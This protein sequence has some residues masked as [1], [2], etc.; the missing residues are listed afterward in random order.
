MLMNFLQ[1]ALA[2]YATVPAR[3]LR[4]LKKPLSGAGSAQSAPM[5]TK[6]DARL[7]A[8]WF[9]ALVDSNRDKAMSRQE[10]ETFLAAPSHDSFSF[11][12]TEFDYYD[13]D[14]SDSLSLTEL[15][16]LVLFQSNKPVLDE[17][18]QLTTQAAPVYTPEPSKNAVQAQTAMQARASQEQARPVAAPQPVA[19]VQPLAAQ[20]LA[21]VQPLA[22]QPLA[23]VQ[24]LAA[25]PVTPAQPL[26]QVQPLAEKPLAQVQ[27]LA[28]Q[29]VAPAQPLAQVQPLAAQPLAPAH[30]QT[31]TQE[32]PQA[33]AQVDMTQHSKPP[34]H[35]PAAWV[36]SPAVGSPDP[37]LVQAAGTLLQQGDTDM[38]GLLSME[39]ANALLTTPGHYFLAPVFAQFEDFDLDLNHGLDVN[40][41][42]NVLSSLVKAQGQ[43]VMGTQTLAA[44]QPV[45][46]QQ[47]TV[48][49]QP[50]VAAQT[51]ETSQQPTVPAQPGLAAQ[52]LETSQQPT[53]P[54]QP[55]LAAQTLETS[56]QPTVPA[57]PGLAAQTLETS[58]Q[59]TVPAQPGV[60]AQPLGTSQQPTVP[61]QPGLAAQPVVAVQPVSG[62]ELAVAAPPLASAQPAVQAQPAPGTEFPV[63]AQVDV[64]ALDS[65]GPTALASDTSDPEVIQAAQIILQRADEDHDGLLSVG[66]AG[67]LPTPG[68]EFLAVVSS[69]FDEFDKDGSKSLDVNELATV[70]ESIN[71]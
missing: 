35:Q 59:P 36:P 51:L 55:G 66:E 3:G 67:L 7:E 8:A 15:A 12:L 52:T 54:A 31:I 49:A 11:F 17:G 34:V 33:Q 9:L 71:E 16:E 70:L 57:Q 14:L 46:S 20:P 6:A 30:A 19:Q 22:A 53:V 41:L 28:A 4:I 1:V 10:L 37:K 32:L 42:I 40:E 13:H 61:A 21:Q 38:D 27:P 23:Q 64:Q 68:H 48:A 24:P 62:A 26:A 2:L 50:G 44:A 47:P 56:Q 63:L 25:Q 5:V 58:Q 65:A 69:R 39:E 43:P 29:P 18:P 60:A 45:E